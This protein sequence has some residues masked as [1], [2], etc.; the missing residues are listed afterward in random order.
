MSVVVLT[1]INF[2][3]LLKKITKPSWQNL[4]ISKYSFV[5]N[6]MKE[7]LI[8][9]NFNT[10]SGQIKSIKK[11]EFCRELDYLSILFPWFPVLPNLKSVALALYI[12]EKY[13]HQWTV[14]RFNSIQ[15]HKVQEQLWNTLCF[16]TSI[17][18]QYH[19]PLFL[20]KISFD[21]AIENRYMGIFRAV[22]S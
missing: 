2:S 21:N 22:Q 1:K 18:H 9:V 10:F 19:T 3:N 6:L 13:W 12:K 11:W 7:I 20:H 8:V 4:A 14:S 5:A 16:W 15:Y 17:A